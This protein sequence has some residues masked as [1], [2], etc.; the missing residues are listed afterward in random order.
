MIASNVTIDG[1][2]DDDGRADVTIDAGGESRVLR[3]AAGAEV[4]A[5]GLQITGGRLD[6]A[7]GISQRGAGIEVESNAS[8]T[9]ENGAITNNLNSTLGNGGGVFSDGALTIANSTFDGN[10]AEIGGGVFAADAQ[11]VGSTV[12][13]NFA[14]ANGGGLAVPG[15]LN[16]INSTVAGNLAQVNGGLIA[17]NGTLTNV[18][19][20][21][22]RSETG[23]ALYPADAITLNNSIVLNNS[24]GETGGT[25]I[26]NN[27]LIGDGTIDPAAVFA[28]G[29]V[30][31][32]GGPVETVELRADASNPALD[33]GDDALAPTTDARGESRFDQ[34]GLDNGGVSDL[35]AF[36]LQ[37]VVQIPE[38]PSL[39]VTTTADVVDA[40]NGETSLREAIAFAN[41]VQDADGQGDDT[42]TITFADGLAFEKG[43][44]IV[45]AGRCH[46]DAAAGAR[47]GG[48]A[49]CDLEAAWQ[50]SAI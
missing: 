13:N 38:D 20:T 15:E 47:A 31:D 11:I 18:T 17:S 33:A 4:T 9:F 2:L 28:T 40:F 36:E 49:A 37:T 44:T 22:N 12:S 32:N 8:L 48:K 29:D 16:L 30:V 6:P 39:E 43:G 27:S 25:I 19:V 35:G 26:S 41:D 7:D 24:G 46:I 5:S 10:T 3:I 50:V 42:D 34:P 14:I 45:L 23:S 21:A 1:D